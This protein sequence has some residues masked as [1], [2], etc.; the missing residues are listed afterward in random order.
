MAVQ[1]LLAEER[2]SSGQFI[3]PPLSSGYLHLSYQSHPC[4]IWQSP[5]ALFRPSAF[6][7]AV[8]G[9]ADA[10]NTPSLAPLLEEFHTTL[11]ETFPHHSPFPF[12]SRCFVFEDGDGQSDV[13]LGTSF[14]DLVMIP[15]IMNN[16]KFYVGTMLA[17]LCHDILAGFPAL[18][19]RCCPVACTV[20][21]CHL[22]DPRIRHFCWT[23]CSACKPTAY[24]L[25]RRRRTKQNHKRHIQHTRSE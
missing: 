17:E 18:V 10:A 25:C 23:R 3:P 6:P 24:P 12:A 20:L 11:S 15:S 13:N 4:P 16:K 14:P 2:C 8:I 9:V 5:L 7:L 21:R 19:S 22:P 1:V